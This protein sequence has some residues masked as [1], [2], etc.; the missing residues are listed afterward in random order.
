MND[1]NAMLHS[2]PLELESRKQYLEDNKNHRLQ[3]DSLVERLNNWVEEAQMK[4][5]PFDSGV[6]YQNIES[7]FEEHK[8]YFSQ[9]TKLRDLLDKI[10][11]TANKIWASLVQHDQDKVSHEQEFFNQL[12]KNTLNSAHSKQAQ[13]EEN[14]KKW[15]SFREVHDQVEEIVGNIVVETERPSSL[16]GVKSSIARID[17]STKLIKQKQADLERYNSKAK[18]IS[19]KADVVNR[20]QISEEQEA[21]NK[22]VKEALGD[23]KDQKETLAS[24][25][26]QWDDFDLK[27]KNFSSGISTCQHKFATIDSTFRSLDQMKEIKNSLKVI[28]LLCWGSIKTRENT[29]GDDQSC[30][31]LTYIKQTKNIPIAVL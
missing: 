12:V 13:L 3:Y 10:H 8:K 25:A 5:R 2:L 28:F 4:L 11:D 16:V 9:E 24:L 26:L 17:S 1:A 7:D 6:D 30:T 15:R 31:V 20:T 14:V 27:A 29:R 19:T 21:L 22:K 23:L 18:E